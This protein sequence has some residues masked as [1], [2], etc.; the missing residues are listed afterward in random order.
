LA[1]RRSRSL[2][3]ARDDDSIEGSAE[4]VR[5][6]ANL[7]ASLCGTGFSSREQCAAAEAE[8]AEHVLAGWF[9]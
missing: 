2:G 7:S 8:L 3:F 4:D 1:H 6:E 5:T 9:Y